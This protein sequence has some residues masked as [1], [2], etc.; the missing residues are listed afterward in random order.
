[1][2][3]AVILDLAPDPRGALLAEPR[4]GQTRSERWNRFAVQDHTGNGAQAD[5]L[6]RV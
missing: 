4:L 2:G 6:G 1:M 5:A 3:R